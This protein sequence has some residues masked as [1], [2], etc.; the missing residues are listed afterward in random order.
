[1]TGTA[2]FL[3]VDGVLNSYPWLFDN[4]PEDCTGL[5]ALHPEMVRR[6]N[7]LVLPEVTW[8]LSSSWR[9]EHSAPAL[10]RLLRQHGWTGWMTDSTPK[11]N[12]SRGEQIAAWVREEGWAGEVLVLDD[13]RDIEPYL[14][15]HVWVD[16]HVGLTDAD[17]DKALAMMGGT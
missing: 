9:Y 14:H 17:V 4:R 8:V 10:S 13:E 2:I 1:M 5:D 6:L 3:D 16:P 15:R 7:R 11:F 12:G